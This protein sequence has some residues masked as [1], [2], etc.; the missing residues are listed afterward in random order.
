[1]ILTHTVADYDSAEAEKKFLVWINDRNE[2]LEVV[3]ITESFRDPFWYFTVWYRV[4]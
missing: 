3:S 4:A 1:V 2:P